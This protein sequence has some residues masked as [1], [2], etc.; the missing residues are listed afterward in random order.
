MGSDR[1]TKYFDILGKGLIVET[2]PFIFRGMV[3]KAVQE[4]SISI[5]KIS[6]L[7][8]SKANLWDTLWPNGMEVLTLYG[9]EVG[10]L[11]WLCAEWFV[12]VLR[13]SRPDLASLFLGWKKSNTWL[14]KQIENLKRN[15]EKQ[16]IS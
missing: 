9:T 2:A 11:D 4:D 12:G 5:G 14:E 15:I 16:I 3:C 13:E 10:K 8:Q 7:V 1:L 6:E